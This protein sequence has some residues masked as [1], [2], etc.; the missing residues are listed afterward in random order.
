MV[1]KPDVEDVP[2]LRG[3]IEFR[4]LTFRYPG[5][6]FDV[7]KNVSFT[8]KP[9]ENVGIIGRTGSGKTTLVDL[10]LRTYNVPDGTIFLDGHDINSLPIKTVR[11]YAAYVPQDNFLFSDTIEN[12]ISFATDGGNFQA[13]E[14]AAKN[15]DVHENITG[16]G[17]GYKTVLGERGVTVS[18]GQK[19]RISIAR[20]LMKD[21]AILILDDS[22]S[23]VD[24]STEKVILD[25][26]KKNRAGKTTIL[27]A[28][29]ITTVEGMD[30]IIFIDDGKIAAVGTH[31]ELVD[32][33]R[34]YREMVELQRLNDA[35]DSTVSADS[36]A[37][38]EGGDL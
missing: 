32:T 27:I 30:K 18:G 6:E 21:A 36:A 9:G 22:V 38:K 26:L 2:E 5:G 8:I 17:L 31:A 33:C 34:D 20:A 37:D 24:V 11:K 4:D 23:A 15:A 1:D 16:F 25:N 19:Q 35:G 13:I 28:H 14:T 12:N 10:L 7:L 29:R 3:G